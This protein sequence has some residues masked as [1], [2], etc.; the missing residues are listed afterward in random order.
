[1][2]VLGLGLNACIRIAHDHIAD[3]A[4]IHNMQP[5]RLE[6]DRPI[7]E[8]ASREAPLSTAAPESGSS[9]GGYSASTPVLDPG[10]CVEERGSNNLTV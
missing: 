9:F 8:T 3:G 6:Q 1:M 10:R 2:R 4:S 5:G 7:A